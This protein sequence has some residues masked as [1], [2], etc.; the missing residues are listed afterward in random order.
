M[1]ERESAVFPEL[2]TS[3]NIPQKSNRAPTVNDKGCSS[4]LPTLLHTLYLTM[5]FSTIMRTVLGF[6]DR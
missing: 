6:H 4:Q 1:L 5:G 3:Q 2:T